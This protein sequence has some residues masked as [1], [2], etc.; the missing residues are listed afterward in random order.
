ME[1]YGVP[2]EDLS[3]TEAKYLVLTDK[4]IA[5]AERAADVDRQKRPVDLNTMLEA[6]AAA[7]REVME[8]L[9][10]PL[11]KAMEGEMVTI[12]NLPRT[13]GDWTMNDD[14]YK[15]YK[16]G[17]ADYLNDQGE[18]FSG[19]KWKALPPEA[20]RTILENNIEAGKEYAKKR[21][22]YSAEQEALQRLN[23]RRG[24]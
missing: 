12:G 7:G 11:R 20:K 22:Q 21:V 19:P 9:L 16:A 3:P 2:W 10:P 6:Q 1:V 14:R 4:M 8:D 5:E 23:K 17:I 15:A 13:F 24:A 18:T